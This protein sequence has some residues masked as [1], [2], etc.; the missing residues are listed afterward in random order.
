MALIKCK[1]R[2]RKFLRQKWSASSDLF[3]LKS[4]YAWHSLL[5]SQAV[6]PSISISISLLIILFL[7]VSPFFIYS[8]SSLSGPHYFL[9]ENQSGSHSEP[10]LQSGSFRYPSNPS[11][12]RDGISEP[13]YIEDSYG[14]TIVAKNITAIVSKSNP[15]VRCYS[16]FNKEYSFLLEFPVLV[17]YNETY[18]VSQHGYYGRGAVYNCALSNASWIASAGMRTDSSYGKQI[19]IELQAL[20]D[21]YPS[22]YSQQGGGSREEDWWQYSRTGSGNSSSDGNG[23]AGGSG[24]NTSG[25]GTGP[26]PPGNIPQA[27]KAVFVFILSQYDMPYG[28]AGFFNTGHNNTAI[29]AGSTEIKINLTLQ[30]LKSVKAEWIAVE[31]QIS[32][33]KS[34][35]TQD[36]VVMLHSGEGS[37]KVMTGSASGSGG[38]GSMSSFNPTAEAKQRITFGN[39]D[40]RAD[41]E[42]SWLKYLEIEGNRTQGMLNTYTTGGNSLK[43]YSAFETG[44]SSYFVFDPAL[45]VA[46][47]ENNPDGDSTG[48]DSGV[49][50]GWDKPL[51]RVAGI[52]VGLIIG[53]G[54]LGMMF[55]VFLPHKKNSITLKENAYYRYKKNR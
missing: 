5:Q 37:L 30:M 7:T 4:N 53:I 28:S 51:L 29:L 31:Q 40:G 10:A 6:I 42:Y 13:Y 22:Q 48:T 32:K 9:S 39:E 19:E 26:F 23:T 16:M 55:W 47:D 17:F 15:A 12:S 18:P 20:L 25:N 1:K 36:A 35:L 33:C 27:V 8:I 43:L 21:L 45:R 50:K 24:G 49:I 52:A 3:N 11:L 46:V 41:A 14:Y 54:I 38:S 2:H 44:N 34:N